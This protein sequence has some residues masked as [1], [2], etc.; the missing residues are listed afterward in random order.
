MTAYNVFQPSFDTAAY[1]AGMKAYNSH[2]TPRIFAIDEPESTYYVLVI[3]G[4]VVQGAHWPHPL[5]AMCPEAVDGGTLGNGRNLPGRSRDLSGDLMRVV[6]GWVRE[7]GF[8]PLSNNRDCDK[9]RATTCMEVQS[10]SHDREH[11]GPAS[12]DRR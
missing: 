4:E 5:R 7:P 1:A 2:D 8:S 10:E 12:E 6:D 9:V 3:G 11:R